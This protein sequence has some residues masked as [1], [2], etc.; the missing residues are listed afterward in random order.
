M[1]NNYKNV[2][3]IY[4]VD[5]N[6]SVDNQ[7]HNQIKQLVEQSI[8]MKFMLVFYGSLCDSD[9]GLQLMKEYNQ[10]IEQK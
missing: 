6:N 9:D 4:V 8:I 1:N 7:V 10:I 5:N 2:Y 3:L